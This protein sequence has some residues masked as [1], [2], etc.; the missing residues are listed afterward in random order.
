[1]ALKKAV[2]LQVIQPLTLFVLNVKEMIWGCVFFEDFF[3]CNFSV[4]A[5][6]VCGRSSVGGRT[7]H[8]RASPSALLEQR[9]GGVSGISGLFSLLGR[10]GLQLGAPRTLWV[11]FSRL[12]LQQSLSMVKSSAL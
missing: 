6:L 10:W 9:P 2:I 4:P 12:S 1:M 3:P 5:F 8:V 11:W 7:T